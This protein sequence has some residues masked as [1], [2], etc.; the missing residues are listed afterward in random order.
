MCWLQCTFWISISLFILY[1][2]FYPKVYLLQFFLNSW[3]TN[4]YTKGQYIFQIGSTLFMNFEQKNQQPEGVYQCHSIC[5]KSCTKSWS[6]GIIE[7]KIGIYFIIIRV[8]FV[9]FRRV[10]I[11]GMLFLFVSGTISMKWK[12]LRNLIIENL[13]FGD[14][15]SY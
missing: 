9:V 12:Q 7:W 15:K 2:V 1:Y 13:M 6:L 14:L 11:G 10:I 8:L 4:Q 5:I 3:K